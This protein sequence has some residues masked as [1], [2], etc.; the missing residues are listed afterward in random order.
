MV[1]FFLDQVLAKSGK[2]KKRILIELR[3]VENGHILVQEQGHHP[4]NAGFGLSPQSEQVDVVSGK[5]SPFDVWNDRVFVSPN[6]LKYV[7][8]SFDLPDPV[9][10][11]L[12]FGL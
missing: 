3:S 9:V 6:T 10:S 12:L 1:P 4:R 8:L 11:N 2:W 7:F 5:N